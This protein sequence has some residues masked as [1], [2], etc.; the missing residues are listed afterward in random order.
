M[1]VALAS[2]APPRNRYRWTPEAASR[3]G[4]ISGES[5]AAVSRTLRIGDFTEDQRRL[6]HALIEAARAAK[7]GRDFES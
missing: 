4:R 5:R 3:A 1:E 2:T 6:I 7:V